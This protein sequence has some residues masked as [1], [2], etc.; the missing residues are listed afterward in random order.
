M[1]NL[2]FNKIKKKYDNQGFVVLKKFFKKKKIDL[3]NIDLKTLL[4]KK[5]KNKNKRF[6]NKVS[7]EKI[8]SLHN[9][10]NWFWSKKLQKEKKI[11]S[12]VKK[13]QDERIEDFG[14][15]VFAKPPK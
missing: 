13:L 6:I 2:D 9:I 3:I 10:Q 7:N 14:S 5:A 15:E 12:L 8:N 11:R 4:E 1:K